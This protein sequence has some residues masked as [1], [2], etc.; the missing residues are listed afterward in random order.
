MVEIRRGRGA[1]EMWRS[2]D[3]GCTWTLADSLPSEEALPGGTFLEWILGPFALDQ[4]RDVLIRFESRR[5]FTQPPGQLKGY[6]DSV[7]ASIPNSYLVYYRCSYDRAQTWGPRRQVIED[8]GEYNENHWARGVSLY[9]GAAVLGEI[10]PYQTLDDGRLMIPYQGRSALDQDRLGT[11]QAGRFY[12]AWD[13]SGQALRWSSGGFVH[14]GGCEQ[15]TERLRDG[16]LLTILRAQG[17]IEPYL[18][19]PWQRPYALSDDDG[20]SWSIPEPLTWDDGAGLTSPRAWS[21]LIRSQANGRLYWIATILP[22]L[23]DAGHIRERWP[24]RADPRY[25]LQIAEVDEQTIA[26]R[27]D[28]LTIIEDRAPEETPFVR[29]S[30]FFAYNERETD[31]LVLLMMKSYHEDQPDLD[32]MPHPAYR[33]R[34]PGPALRD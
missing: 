28:T 10:P 32:H 33:Y 25:P 8:D 20:Q 6:Y 26:L 11:I 12:A 22:A 3:N 1:S 17:Q 14:G 27:R 23:E 5:E 24:S 21:Q 19:S 2:D 29:F 13:A 15:T 9:E 31:D 16:R 7:A 18:F 4:H 34:I 30:N